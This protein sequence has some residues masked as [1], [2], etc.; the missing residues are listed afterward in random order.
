MP[1]SRQTLQ[2]KP[3]N[4]CIN[5]I[6]IG[7]LC[8]GPNFLAMEIERW[9]EWCRL[10]KEYLGWTNSH[11]AELA[12]VSKIS[13]DRIMRVDIKDLRIST[14]QAVTKALING[15]WGKYPCVLAATGMDESAAATEQ[16]NKLLV[17]IDKLKSDH[18]E[19]LQELR[20]EH[21]KAI[22]FLKEQLKFKEE[23]MLSKDKLLEAITHMI[24]NGR[25]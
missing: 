1:F 14:M 11:I 10:R 3:Y 25:K 7:Q 2:E 24:D 19:Q 18:K 20:T 23:Q 4:Q 17:E 9:C 13:V 15:T 21:A 6:H 22:A 16:C 12:E 5:C 8:D